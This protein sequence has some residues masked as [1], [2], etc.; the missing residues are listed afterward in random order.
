MSVLLQL[1]V[2]IQNYAWQI[3]WAGAIFTL[4]EIMVPQSR[5]SWISRARGLIFWAVYILVTAS[6][7]TLFYMVWPMLG[8]GRLYTIPIG[9]LFKSQ[10]LAVQVAGWVAAPILAGIL[11]DFF[12]YWFHRMQHTVPAFWHFHK[13]HHSAVSGHRPRSRS[14]PASCGPCRWNARTV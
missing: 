12:Y 9:S 10:Y 4:A 2:G 11:S 8:L 7:L 13:V 6:A 1:S 14:G 5:Y 3:I